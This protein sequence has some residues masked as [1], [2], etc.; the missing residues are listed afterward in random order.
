[1]LNRLAAKPLSTGSTFLFSMTLQTPFV[2]RRATQRLVKKDGQ[3][4]QDLHAPFLRVIQ[5]ELFVLFPLDFHFV[6]ISV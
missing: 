1:M 6:C 4:D 2:A 3:R 5:Q